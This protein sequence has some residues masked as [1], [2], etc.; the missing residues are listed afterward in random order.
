MMDVAVAVESE[1]SLIVRMA[2][3][4]EKGATAEGIAEFVRDWAEMFAAKIPDEE[5]EDAVYMLSHGLIYWWNET[6]CLQMCKA[7]CGD[8][9]SSKQNG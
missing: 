4:F 2:R 7:D 6:Y 1:A 9:E 5:V 8:R 3:V